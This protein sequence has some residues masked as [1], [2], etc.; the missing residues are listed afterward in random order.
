[1]SVYEIKRVSLMDVPGKL[2]E[3]ADTFEQRS[4]EL[5]TA[6]VIV[7]HASGHVQVRGYGERT[8]NLEATGW[9]YR[10][11]TTMSEHTACEDNPSLVP[12]APD[13]A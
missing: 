5:R 1:M 4:A 9:L 7:G 11:L 3:L 6:I 12:P 10:A 8:T 2:R 13:S